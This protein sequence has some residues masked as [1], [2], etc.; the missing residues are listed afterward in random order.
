MPDDSQSFRKGPDGE[1]FD[2]NVSLDPDTNQKVVNWFDIQCFV[3]N[4]RFIKNGNTFI[5]NVQQE[6]C[7]PRH[8]RH[9]PGVILEVIEGEDPGAASVPLNTPSSIIPDS[10]SLP[11]APAQTPGSVGSTDPPLAVG[12]LTIHDTAS[13][14]ASVNK[15]VTVSPPPAFHRLLQRTQST[16]QESSAQFVSYEKHMQA[17]Q[18]VRTDAFEHGMQTIQEIQGNILTLRS[19]VANCDEVEELKQKI[20]ELQLAAEVHSQR[21]EE[22]HRKSVEPQERLH[23][24]QQEA[25]NRIVLIQSKIA[26]IMT[27]NYELYECPIPRLFIVL[28]KEDTIKA[29][30]LDRGIKNPFTRTFKVHFLC[31]CGDH[32]KSVDG[33]ATNTNLKDE[34]HITRHEG[35]DVEYPTEFF[36]KYGSYILMLLQMLKYGVATA[37]VVV[38]P[39]GQLQIVDSLE[40]VAEGIDRVLGNVGTSIDIS[41]AYIEGLAGAQSQPPS[42]E[43]DLS[44]NSSTLVGPEVLKGADLRQ[45]DSFLKTKSDGRVH[46]NLHRTVTADG[47]VKWVCLDHYRENY[48]AKA[49]QDFRD[50]VDEVGGK[51]SEATGSLT[52]SLESPIVAR[53]FY[54]VLSSWR[55]VQEIDIALCW[56][57]SMQDLGELRDAIKST[58]A[59]RVRLDGGNG[60]APLSDFLNNGRRFDPVLQMLSGGNIRTF[61]LTGWEGFLGSID[62][63]PD[64]LSIRE[65]GIDVRSHEEWSEHAPR[66]IE[67]LQASPMLS[68][69]N[70]HVANEFKSVLDPL[71]A[72][73]E[74]CKLLQGL[75]LV[76]T[77]LPNKMKHL[78]FSEASVEF[79][80]G[81]GKILSIV[82]TIESTEETKLFDHP[83]VREIYFYKSKGPSGPL[84][85]LQR[86]L[87]S[88][89]N[90][91]RI[92]VD[93]SE[94]IA[95]AWLELLQV[96]F[97]KHPRHTPQV[98][99]SD[100]ASII[101]TSDIHDPTATIIDIQVI[102]N[103]SISKGYLNRAPRFGTFNIK[104]VSFGGDTTWSDVNTLIRFWNARQEHIQL[105][106]L[107]VCIADRTDP[108]TFD[109]LLLFLE[110]LNVLESL[111]VRCTLERVS[112]K[113]NF[114]DLP[115][116]HGSI[117]YYLQRYATC[118]EVSGRLLPYHQS[119]PEPIFGTP[120][121][122]L[123]ELQVISLMSPP[124][125]DFSWILSTIQ[126][127]CPPG[128]HHH[129]PKFD[130]ED[131]ECNRLRG[132]YLKDCRFSDIQWPEL[133]QSIDV[134]TLN[135]L[136]VN[137]WGGFRETHLVDL[138]DRCISTATQVMQLPQDPES[139]TDQL[140]IQD[141]RAQT[142]QRLRICLCNVY[143]TDDYIKEQNERLTRLGLG[144]IRLEREAR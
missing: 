119:T 10:Y 36:E 4:A 131:Q 72:S 144:W 42:S 25:L 110:K 85:H 68:K 79:E 114:H 109:P 46:G 30:R 133:I 13:S 125:Q 126:R 26:A 104:T 90:L 100:S 76:M 15:T 61:E 107:E 45:L 73:L 136:S 28:P 111:R 33:Q 130:R 140:A 123:L 17:G 98:H 43:P 78:E 83:S 88:Y 102:S 132:L 24:A 39:L 14:F 139:L 91:E 143:V 124:P 135:L 117:K 29:E 35:Y 70:V 77:V 141:L 93:S 74:R 56:D 113:A 129:S 120:S 27:Q 96:V 66:F 53:K 65:L 137:G 128:S 8:I 62:T 54:K 47:Q 9:Y 95:F 115:P 84:K 40:N 44:T 86:C 3:P 18:V 48:K 108:S 138:V 49:A 142:H 55:V 81:T 80:A 38:P 112:N 23:M 89:T 127:N 60:D 41:I 92:E 97:A 6:W 122:R 1:V 103:S 31:E 63:I 22:M 58:T 50:A 19:E 37:G 20:L 12:S 7:E 32:T 69:V 94:D 21:M 105:T 101:S 52:L 59:F 11:L 71:A 118:I 121:R 67:I 82:L 64:T 5:C 16:L 106:A 99:L 134:L 51:Y 34:V 57:F 75:T 87:G 2:I 116:S